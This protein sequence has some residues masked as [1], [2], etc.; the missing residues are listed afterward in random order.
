M[1]APG[2][3]LLLVDFLAERDIFDLL[4]LSSA[5]LLRRLVLFY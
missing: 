3:D 1:L 4:P 5:E 2:L